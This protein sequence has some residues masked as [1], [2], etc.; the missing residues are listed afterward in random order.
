MDK[1]LSLTMRLKLRVHYLMCSFCERYM[2][3]LHYIRE[4]AREFPEKIGDVSSASLSA[5]AK[6]RMK[7]T[8]A[9]GGGSPRAN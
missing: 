1:D 3:Q 8:L 5:G 2:K 4:V 6:E 9:A 7:A